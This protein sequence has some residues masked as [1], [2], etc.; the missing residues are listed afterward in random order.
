L[1]GRG[2][3]GGDKKIFVSDEEHFD[4][5]SLTDE[6]MAVTVATPSAGWHSNDDEVV[7]HNNYEFAVR[8]LLTCPRGRRVL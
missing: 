6:A 1:D 8:K 4:M 7:V 5:D 3:N 2:G